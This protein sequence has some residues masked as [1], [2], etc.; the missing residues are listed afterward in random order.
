[1]KAW[2]VKV[3]ITP[4]PEGG[5][6]AEVPYLQGCWIVAPT[7]EEAIRDIYEVI[8]MSIASRIRH[9]EAL[10]PELEEVRL[11]T[12]GTIKLDVAVAVP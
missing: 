3:E 5:Y 4:W 2:K 6:Q 1:M 11:G 10:P 9:G 12:Q 7:V 8:E